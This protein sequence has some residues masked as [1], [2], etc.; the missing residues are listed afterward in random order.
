MPGNHVADDLQL[1]GFESIPLCRTWVKRQEVDFTV[2]QIAQGRVG[3]SV[4][5]FAVVQRPPA[6]RAHGD[7]FVLDDDRATLRAVLAGL[8]AAHILRRL[9]HVNGAKESGGDHREYPF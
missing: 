2:H 4:H 8:S 1:R 3:V 6:I 5:S 7:V 9:R